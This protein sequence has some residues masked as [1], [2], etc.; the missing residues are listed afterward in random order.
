MCF[1]AD[2]CED[3]CEDSWLLGRLD[4]GFMTPVSSTA[5]SGPA[6][7]TC[8]TFDNQKHWLKQKTSN[9]PQGTITYP[10]LAGEKG[11]SS[12]QKWRLGRGYVRSQEGILTS[13]SGVT[14]RL[15]LVPIICPESCL[16]AQQISEALAY[17]PKGTSAVSTQLKQRIAVRFACIGWTNAFPKSPGKFVEY[18]MY[19]SSWPRVF[20]SPT[21]FL[22]IWM[23]LI[24]LIPI[25]WVPLSFRH[26]RNFLS[27]LNLL[28]PLFSS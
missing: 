12:T 1:G 9:T 24:K 26:E 5:S 4:D 25:P 16:E 14:N 28:S 3:N 2:I 6:C 10:T 23:N 17:C 8:K 15:F 13:S 20:C 27:N 22:G 21:S 19:I 11:Q 18:A 7:N